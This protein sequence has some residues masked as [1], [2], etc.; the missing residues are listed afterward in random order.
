[1]HLF[2]VDLGPGKVYRESEV[3]APGGEAVVAGTPW[4][5]LGLS[6]CY[7]LRFAALYRTLAKGGAR[8][9][10]VPAAFTRT[11]GEAHWHILHAGA[12]DR[13]RRASSSHPARPENS[14]A[15]GRPTATR[16]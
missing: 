3:V 14:S 9:L 4:G 8:M 7:D 16:W 12:R 1:M 5:G 2:D 15:A 6:V 11:T 10:A 13:E